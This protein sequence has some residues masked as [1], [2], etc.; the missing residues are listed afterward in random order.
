MAAA[1]SLSL[2]LTDEG[3]AGGALFSFRLTILHCQWRDAVSHQW[4]LSFFLSS[5]PLVTTKALAALPLAWASL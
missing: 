5:L 3:R 1:L 2:F 4:T